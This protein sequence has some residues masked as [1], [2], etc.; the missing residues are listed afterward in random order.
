MN[1]LGNAIDAAGCDPTVLVEIDW[2][3]SQ[4]AVVRFDITV[5]CGREPAG[6]VEQTRAPGVELLS[7]ATRERDMVFKRVL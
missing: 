4:D 2:I 5:V 1:A 6:H 3:V 7:D